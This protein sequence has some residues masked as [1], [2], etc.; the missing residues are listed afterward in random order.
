MGRCRWAGKAN[1]GSNFAAQSSNGPGAAGHG[2]LAVTSPACANPGQ[3]WQTTGNLASL[4]PVAA[5]A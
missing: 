4:E 3:S 2:R 1:S 5:L